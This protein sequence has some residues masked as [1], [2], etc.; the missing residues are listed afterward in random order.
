MVVPERSLANVLFL[1]NLSIH[2]NIQK[3][4][5]NM[6]TNIKINTSRGWLFPSNT[7]SSR[8]ESVFSNVSST[9]Y[10]EQIQALVNNIT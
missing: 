9:R 5:N 8:A 7:N 10:A 4:A 6:A 3:T 2:T 1:F